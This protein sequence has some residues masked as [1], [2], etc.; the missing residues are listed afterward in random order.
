[1]RWMDN[2]WGE[3]MLVDIEITE[4]LTKEHAETGKPYCEIVNGLIEECLDD[5]KQMKRVEQRLS[6]LLDLYV[7][8]RPHGGANDRIQS[9]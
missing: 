1:M 9:T 4:L 6:E 7:T 8:N 3:N 2:A 5:E